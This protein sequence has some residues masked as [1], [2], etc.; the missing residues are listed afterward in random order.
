MLIGNREVTKVPI[1][2]NYLQN[3]V[4]IEPIV[5]TQGN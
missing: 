4:Y 1:E 3:M 2:K 5:T